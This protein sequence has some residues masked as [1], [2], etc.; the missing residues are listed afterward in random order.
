MAERKKADLDA[1]N[2]GALAAKKAEA[3]R[4]QLMAEQAAV[5]HKP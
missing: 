5:M 2:A 4:L 1:Q 3:K